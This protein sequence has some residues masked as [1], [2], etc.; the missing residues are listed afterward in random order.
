MVRRG[1][2]VVDVFTPNA[3]FIDEARDLS[4]LMW[5][6]VIALFPDVNTVII[7]SDDDHTM[8]SSLHGATPRI[9]LHI[10]EALK[11]AG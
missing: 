8:Y 2:K 11:D 5:L 6:D 10:A 7:T 3:L 4:P 9:M 1:K